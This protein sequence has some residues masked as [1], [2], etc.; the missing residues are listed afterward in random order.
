MNSSWGHVGSHV[1]S[2]LTFYIDNDP[3]I[4]FV[5]MRQRGDSAASLFFL[6]VILFICWI[7]KD[8]GRLLFAT[9]TP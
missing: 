6:A 3:A 2:G 7:V 8:G 1:G 5:D 9:D 4:F